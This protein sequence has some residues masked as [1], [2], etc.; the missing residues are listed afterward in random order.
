MKESTVILLVVGGFVLLMWAVSTG[1]LRTTGGNIQLGGGIVAPQPTQNYSGYL[2]ASTA[3]GVS[4]V[5]NTALSGL[6]GSVAGWFGGSGG[7]STVVNQGPVQPASQAPTAAAQPSGPTPSGF[8]SGVSAPA[9]MNATQYTPVGPIPP[10]DISYAST[11]QSAFNY[12]AL[13]NANSYDPSYDMS[14]GAVAA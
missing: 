10:P 3:G 1:V 9:M 2:A 5:L 4:D 7:S 11:S 13:A 6:S 14:T 8:Y 12:D